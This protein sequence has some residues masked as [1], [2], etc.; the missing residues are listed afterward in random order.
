MT[1]A[2]TWRR[3]ETACIASLALLGFCFLAKAATP[4][5]FA[6]I[7]P[8]LFLLVG[9]LAKLAFQGGGAWL[10]HR[11]AA[12]F[13]PGSNVRRAWE[14]LSLGL[15]GFFLGQLLLA[16]YQIVLRTRSPFPSPAD[17]FFLLSYPLLIAALALFVRA[18]Q[19]AGFPLGTSGE[20]WALLGL[21]AA[22]CLLLAYPILAPIARSQAPFLEKAINLAYPILDLVMLLPTALLFRATLRLHGGDVQRVW[23]ALLAGVLTLAG[24]DMAFAYSSTLGVARLDPVAD[25]LLLVGY[26][27]FALSSLAQRNLLSR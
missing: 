8:W 1:S 22:V 9:C 4:G 16:R 10:A 5:L 26:G 27:C 21:T 23:T 11:C 6:E 19:Q 7:D 17:V 15:L 20:R 14:L 2:L 13:E 3:E 12:G 25:A 18:Y 24:G